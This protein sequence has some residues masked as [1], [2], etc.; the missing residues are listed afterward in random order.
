M[1]IYSHVEMQWDGE[2]YVEL[3]SA[4]EEYDGPLALCGSSGGSSSGSSTTTIRYA[5]YVETLH[6]DFLNNVQWNRINAI[7]WNPFNNY[8]NINADYMFF[9]ALTIASFPSLYSVFQDFMYDHDIEASWNTIFENT[10]NSPIVNDLIV[11]EA[12]MMEDD[13][14]INSVPRLQTGM[15]DIN[16]VMSSSFVIGKAIID[17]ARVKSV[18]RFSAGLKH[19]LIPVATSRWSTTLEWRKGLVGLYSELLK[20]YISAKTDID[21]INYAMSAKKVLWPFTVLDFERA[22][23]GALQGATN[24]KTDVAGASTTAK[25]LSGA[26]SGAAMGAMVGSNITTTST[27]AAGQAVSGTYAGYGALGGAALGIAAALTY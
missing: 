8:V 13:I 10:I 21:E 27:N 16:A 2:K 3:F 7:T 25:V 26:L 18:S 17:D 15:R 5:T 24:S 12:A 1:K 19:A 23:L 9:G 11:A 6:A 14:N 4:F 20:F 22:A